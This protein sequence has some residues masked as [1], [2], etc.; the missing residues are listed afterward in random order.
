MYELKLQGDP[1]LY[2]KAQEVTQDDEVTD[3]IRAMFEVVTKHEGV[4]LAANQVG[5]LERII[6]IQTAGFRQVFINPKIVKRYPGKGQSREGC[7]SH[8]GVEVKI[9]RTKRIVVEGFDEYWRPIKRNLVGLPSYV[10]QHEIDHL[11][12][13][14]IVG[15]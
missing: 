8:P 13:I 6:L 2:L 15:K 3:I 1:N 10:V 4:G 5:V 14:N 9:K 7:L 11:N 12:G